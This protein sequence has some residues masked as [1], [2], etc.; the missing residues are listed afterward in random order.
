MINVKSKR[1]MVKEVASYTCD[2][3]GITDD[4]DMDMQEYHRV[5]F[6]GGYKSIFGDGAHIR[7]D[8]CQRCL[9][10]LI[11][12]FCMYETENGWKKLIEAERKAD[13]R[14]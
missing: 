1:I 8:I 12:D 10:K 9:L 2:V 13:D 7:C 4:N 11:G 14:P 3:C 5:D 6:I